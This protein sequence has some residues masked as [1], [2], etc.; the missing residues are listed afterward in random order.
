MKLAHQ[1]H[2]RSLFERVDE[3]MD[4]LKRIG[5]PNFG[6]TYEQ[7]ARKYTRYDKGEKALALRRQKD[8]HYGHICKMFDTKKRQCTVYEA[9][10]GVCRDY[11]AGEGD[12]LT[13]RANAGL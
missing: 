13:E 6:L 11:P 9:R 5:R 8:R 2:N 7:T 1:C 10:P 12:C 3:T 4:V